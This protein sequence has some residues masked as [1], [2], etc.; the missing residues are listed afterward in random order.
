MPYIKQMIDANLV[1]RLTK[2]RQEL[3]ENPEV[4][5]KEYDTTKLLKELLLEAGCDILSLNVATGLVAEVKGAKPGPTV[6]YRA[7]ID[8]LP[9][10]EETGLAY[11]SKNDGVSHACGHDF[12]MTLGLGAAFL[13]AERKMDLTGNVRFIFQPAEET[14]QGA[15]QMIEA[16]L[17]A[18]DMIKAVFGVHNQPNIPAGKVGLTDGNLMGAVDTIKIRITGKSGHG[19]IPQHTVD[20]V[21]AGSAVVMGLQSAVSRNIDPFEPVVITIGSF[22]SGTTHNV[23]A[24]SCEL[25]GTVRS[26][27]PKVRAMLPEM[28]ERISRDIAKGYGAQANLD[29]IP[30]V[31]AIANDKT[32]TELARK[33]VVEVFGRDGVVA[34]E[35]TL[36][37]EDFSLYQQYVPGCYFWIGT[38]DEVQGIN[39]GWHHPAFLVNDDVIPDAVRSIVYVLENALNHFSGEE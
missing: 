10:Q 35:P 29:F 3:H 9:I 32:M 1:T 38:G 15:R 26:F 22:Q 36:G 7:D 30:Q 27:N 12:H 37:G 23:I 18:D 24:G 5:S 13:L 6:A 28:I 31:P 8:A 17:F 11:K 34:P 20:A 2:I 16:G 21:V 14:T 4:S 19:A 39:K 25:T 33:S